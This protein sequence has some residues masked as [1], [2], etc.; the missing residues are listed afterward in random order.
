[1]NITGRDLIIYILQNNLENEPVIKDGKIIGLMT[2]E[3]A[4]AKWD[5]GVSTVVAYYKLG[6]IPGAVL[7]GKIYI[8]SPAEKPVEGGAND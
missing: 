7:G 1:M 2:V 6:L 3:E 8:S 5:V 4:A